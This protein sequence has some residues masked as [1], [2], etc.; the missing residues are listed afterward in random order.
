MIPHPAP[1]DAPPAP[2]P[3]TAAAVL[4]RLGPGDADAFRELRLLALQTAPGSFGA[5]WED[6][7]TRPPSAFAARLEGSVVLAAESGGGLL[8][9]AGLRRDEGPR[10]RH[11]AFVWGVFVRPEARGHGLAGSLLRALLRAAPDGV[12]QVRLSV[13]AGNA[14]ARALYARLGFTPYGL[15]PRALKTPDGYI[16]EVLMT[17]GLPLP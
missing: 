11:K 15:E 3:P 7:S 1:D 13:S 10:E 17:V 8:A 14:P 6:E 4:R 2:T 12:E 16:D 5:T 9:C